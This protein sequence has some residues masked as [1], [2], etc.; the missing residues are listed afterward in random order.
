MTGRALAGAQVG[1]KQTDG[2]LFVGLDV[3][4]TTVKC[5]VVEPDTFEIVW[6]RYER[7]ETRQ[8]EKIA[9]M[10]GEMQQA[11]PDIRPQDIRTF[12]TGSGAAP[13]AQCCRCAATSASANR[14]SN[15]SATRGPIATT[16]T[17]KTCTATSAS[18]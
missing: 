11:F 8:A 3:G 7:H 16:A 4:S 5:V 12:I 15:S 14:G 10:L 13:I 6:S 1:K 2:R 18:G 9:D 17:T